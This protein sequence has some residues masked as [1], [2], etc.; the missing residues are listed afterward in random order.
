MA[1]T[2]L[3][4]PGQVDCLYENLAERLIERKLNTELPMSGNKAA[5]AVAEE[6]AISHRANVHHQQRQEQLEAAALEF[7]DKLEGLSGEVEGL[8]VALRKMHYANVALNH[9]LQPSLPVLGNIARSGGDLDSLPEEFSDPERLPLQIFEKYA[10]PVG[11]YMS[12]LEDIAARASVYDRMH[13]TLTEIAPVQ[14]RIAKT[15]AKCSRPEKQYK[16]TM[17]ILRAEFQRVHSEQSRPLIHCPRTAIGAL[18]ELARRFSRVL[19]MNIKTAFV[20]DEIPGTAGLLEDLN[21]A[22]QV[23]GKLSSFAEDVSLDETSLLPFSAVMKI[24][25]EGPVVL[26]GLLGQAALAN[27][28]KRLAEIQEG[29]K[30]ALRA[31]KRSLEIERRTLTQATAADLQG[32]DGAL[33]AYALCVAVGLEQPSLEPAGEWQR[34]ARRLAERLTL[35]DENSYLAELQRLQRR[36]IL[37]SDESDLVWARLEATLAELEQVRTE[38]NPTLDPEEIELQATLLSE[39]GFPENEIREWA[40]KPVAEQIDILHAASPDVINNLGLLRADYPGLLSLSPKRLRAALAEARD[41]LSE[42]AE[43]GLDPVHFETFSDLEEA[44]L[45]RAETDSPAFSD[46]APGRAALCNIESIFRESE[47]F[48]EQPRL[49]PTVCA[50]ILLLGIQKG[51]R[52]AVRQGHRRARQYIYSEMTNALK[53]L[54]LEASIPDEFAF[55]IQ[56]DLLRREGVVLRP[57]AEEKYRINYRLSLL[58]S[59]FREAMQLVLEFYKEKAGE[60]LSRTP[61]APG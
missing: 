58:D 34:H 37:T 20:A 13:Q 50:A 57:N 17:Q 35:E 14:Q 47:Y 1:R 4:R 5:A 48:A 52:L 30:E 28:A 56:L 16:A 45:Q 29:L 43:Q 15:V 36:G 19:G 41:M 49:D 11:G 42:A 44:L 3:S 7:M 6:T 31:Q 38:H 8:R 2:Y 23:G 12:E 59:P 60:R 21:I 40:G 27:E 10:L 25:I 53:A 55:N 54:E 39:L 46:P 32:P 9:Y 24:L 22:A 51:G 18:D 26:E 33:L 61:A